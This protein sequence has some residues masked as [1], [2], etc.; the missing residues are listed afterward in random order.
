MSNTHPVDL[1]QPAPSATI[2]WVGK[3]AARLPWLRRRWKRCRRIEADAAALIERFGTQAYYE[4]GQLSKGYG[5]AEGDQ[6]RVHWARVKVEI[7]RRHEIDLG[8]NGYVRW[9]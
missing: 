3:I 1:E 5:L 4:A 6:S 7:A 9:E 2:S 8:L